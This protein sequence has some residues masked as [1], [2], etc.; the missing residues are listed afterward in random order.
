MSYTYRRT[1]RFRETDAAG[2]VYFANVLAMCHDAYEAS[3]AEA[4]ID[5]PAFFCY[6]KVA[7]PITNATVDFFQPM[8][9]GD[10]QIIQL[11]PRQLGSSE[12]ETLY[13]IFI[14]PGEEPAPMTCVARASTRHVCINAIARAK[15]SLPPEVLQWLRRWGKVLDE[16]LL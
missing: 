1:V 7:F 5:L 16:D 3:L 13:E 6:P 14:D 4:G 10:R 9:C 12:F 8:F 11:S 15:A 2:V